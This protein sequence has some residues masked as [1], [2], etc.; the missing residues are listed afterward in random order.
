MNVLVLIE[1][2]AGGYRATAGDEA[3]AFFIAHYP[4]LVLLLPKNANLYRS[5]GHR[6]P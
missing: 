4:S 6:I 5:V 2:I 1:P 3:I